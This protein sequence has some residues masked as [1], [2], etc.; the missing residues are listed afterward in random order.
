MPT[1]IQR[2][3]LIYTHHEATLYA[4]SKTSEKSSWYLRIKRLF[5]SAPQRSLYEELLQRNYFLL[6]GDPP[7]ELHPYLLR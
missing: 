2:C 1:N 7:Q 4:S 6:K 5:S 3:W